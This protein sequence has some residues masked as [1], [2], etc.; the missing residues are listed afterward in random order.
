MNTLIVIVYPILWIVALV[1]LLANCVGVIRKEIS[2]AEGLRWVGASIAILSLPFFFESTGNG[3][4]AVL[5]K[6]GTFVGYYESGNPFGIVRQPTWDNYTKD[7]IVLSNENVYL[8]PN[9]RIIGVRFKVTDDDGGSESFLMTFTGYNNP[10]VLMR[11]YKL[12]SGLSKP[13]RSGPREIVGHIVTKAKEA[14]VIRDAIRKARFENRELSISEKAGL[15][16][17][18]GELDTS[19]REY[20]FQIVDITLSVD[21]GVSI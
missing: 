4:Y 5:E 18:L 2:L 20:G 12:L 19:L 17:Q 15:Y 14:Q 6:D 8:M 16:L 13:E 1:V 11:R 10:E 21:S 3:R 9:P 7:R